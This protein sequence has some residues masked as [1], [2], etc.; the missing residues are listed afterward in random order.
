MLANVPFQKHMFFELFSDISLGLP[1]SLRTAF[2]LKFD[3]PTA[4]NQVHATA[5]T[6]NAINLLKW[7]NTSKYLFELFQILQNLKNCKSGGSTNLNQ[8]T[9]SNSGSTAHDLCRASRTREGLCKVFVKVLTKAQAYEGTSLR[10]AHNRHA[11]VVTHLY[12]LMS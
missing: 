12:R 8:F 4:T 6:A 5:L 10:T 7:P 11:N 9:N 3:L 1:G 2:D